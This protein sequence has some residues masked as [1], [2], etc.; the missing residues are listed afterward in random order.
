MRSKI[1]MAICA[2]LFAGSVLLVQTVNGHDLFLKLKTFFLSPDSVATISL[3][4]GTFAQSDNS[5]ARDRML[6]VSVVGPADE[7]ENPPKS[8]WRDENNATLLDY[9]TGSAGTYTIGVSTAPRM[10]E[11][12]ADDFN[13]YLKHD[14]IVDTLK[15]RTG[16]AELDQDVNE[17]YSKHVKAIVQVGDQQ[18]SGFEANLGYPVEFVP[19]QNPYSLDVGESLDVVFLKGGQPV[20]NQMIYASHESF[21]GHDEDGNHVEAFSARTD[22]KGVVSIK[23]NASGRWYVRRNWT[24]TTSITNR[25]GP[26]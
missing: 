18:S 19:L 17:R 7:I 12:S 13:E 9:R 21:H 3:V 24:R 22:E 2:G 11:L 10:I 8:A 6:N 26:R 5:I 16:A 1:A 20:A 15:S 25:T 23:L 4:N 14:G